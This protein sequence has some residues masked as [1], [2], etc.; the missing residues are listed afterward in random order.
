[1]LNSGLLPI[2][3]F[4]DHPF[5]CSFNCDPYPIHVFTL[6]ILSETSRML[7]GLNSLAQMGGR[8]I[9]LM[10]ALRYMRSSPNITMILRRRRMKSA[11]IAHMIQLLCEREISGQWE[12]IGFKYWL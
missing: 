11:I 6:A 5:T 12:H 1:M 9:C 2:S 7:I 3:D 10:L 4:L 8:E